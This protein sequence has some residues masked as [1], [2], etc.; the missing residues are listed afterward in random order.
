MRY[1]I[2]VCIALFAYASVEKKIDANSKKLASIESNYQQMDSRLADT[3]KKIL[4]AK[5]RRSALNSDIKGLEK[6]LVNK[7]KVYSV[8]QKKLTEKKLAL[9]ELD[10]QKHELETR[11][12]KLLSQ[13]FGLSMALKD[14]KIK[15][16]QGFIDQYLFEATSEYTHKKIKEYND[17][18][19]QMKQNRVA[20]AKK[21]EE[22]ETIIANLKQKEQTLQKKRA[23]LDSLIARLNRDKD[24]Y[25]KRL[26]RISRQKSDLRKTLQK[27]RIVAREQQ[28]K[29]A[30]EQIADAARE[31]ERLRLSRNDKDIKVRQIGSSYYHDNLYRY[32]GPKTISPLK[33]AKLVRNFGTYTDPIYDI[34]IFNESVVLKAPRTPANVRNVLNGEVMYAEETQM[35]GKVVIIKH[36]NSLHTIYAGLSKISPGLQVGQKVRKG[37][38]IGRV[39]SRLT[40]EATKYSKHL[41]P[42]RLI[43]LR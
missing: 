22:F 36:A 35:L 33:G 40:F 25:K 30:Q 17:K 9:K 4:R 15:T 34:K 18:I 14:Q 12:R 1:L 32:R 3:A 11:L 10:T 19:T 42:T 37:F 38:V 24:S 43:S 41:N 26:Q 20:L 28:E 6:Q 31:S 2:I 16:K 27:L 39:Q 5:K 13:E 29:K 21:T 23:S 8:T 7:E